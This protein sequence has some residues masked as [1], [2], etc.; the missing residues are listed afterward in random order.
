VRP[1]AA[2]RPRRT[3]RGDI[4]LFIVS[5]TDKK[6]SINKWVGAV[7]ASDGAGSAQPQAFGGG[8]CLFKVMKRGFPDRIAVPVLERGTNSS[9]PGSADNSTTN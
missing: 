8:V 9:T 4:A 1:V 3:P 5:T 2:L 7:I 6:T